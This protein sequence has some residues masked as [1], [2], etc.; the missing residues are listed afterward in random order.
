MLGGQSFTYESSLYGPGRYLQKV[1][2]FFTP[3]LFHGTWR[4]AVWDVE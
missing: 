1:H 3:V 2:K 4:E